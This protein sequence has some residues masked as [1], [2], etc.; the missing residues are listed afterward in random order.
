[1]GY[2]KKDATQ[3]EKIEILSMIVKDIFGYEVT[4]D[5]ERWDIGNL[6]LVI[7]N[8]CFHEDLLWVLNR[9]RDSFYVNLDVEATPEKLDE[10]ITDEKGKKFKPTICYTKLNVELYKKD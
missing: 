10:E 7:K 8:I 9:L 1:M 6:Q 4:L 5:F 3:E 2:E